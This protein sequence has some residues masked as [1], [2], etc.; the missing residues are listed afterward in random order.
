MAGCCSLRL[1]QLVSVLGVVASTVAEGDAKLRGVTRQLPTVTHNKVPRLAAFARAHRTESLG[2]S[3]RSEYPGAP[4]I[5]GLEAIPGDLGPLAESQLSMIERTDKSADKVVHNIIAQGDMMQTQMLANGESL[6]VVK[7][8]AQTVANMKSQLD[9]LE[10]R[11]NLC[12]KRSDALKK[13]ALAT[14]L[15]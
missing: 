6:K 11:L 7:K 1:I 12:H 5:F 4:E 3:K 9:L 10:A 15:R 8:L 13:E 14:F 2:R